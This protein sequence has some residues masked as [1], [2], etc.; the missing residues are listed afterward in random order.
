MNTR[1]KM[2]ALQ[3]FSAVL[4]TGAETR[5]GEMLGLSQPAVSA[6]LAN[7]ETELG[8]KLFD[9]V[10]GRLQPTTEAGY[11][12]EYSQRLVSQ[13]EN[14]DKVAQD[15]RE[16]NS[17]HI[18]IAANPSVSLHVLPQVIARFRKSHPNIE[19]MIQTQSSHQVREALH[20]QQFDIGIAEMPV[21]YQ[22]VDVEE[23]S[24]LCVCVM[25]SGHPLEALE[26]VTPQDMVGHPTVVTAREHMVT[27]RLRRIFAEAG[28]D[29]SIVVEAQLVDVTCSI[30]AQGG[31]IAVIDTM[32]AMDFAHRGVVAR[33]FL[34][35]ITLDLAVMFPRTRP[36]SIA[37][38]AFH[39]ML[40]QEMSSNE[41]YI[42]PAA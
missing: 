24:S 35:R 29:L 27:D 20:T 23:I 6:V 18:R 16:A 36:R 42:I 14:L 10:K 31:G 17:G 12:Y 34:P 40:Q 15:I 38:R 2:R 7:L 25:P 5:A 26:V 11:F 4:R 13:F 37:T 8:F 30:V 39:A 22:S 3:I 21:L 33:P 32:T 19:L 9:R 28:L 41:G 1:I